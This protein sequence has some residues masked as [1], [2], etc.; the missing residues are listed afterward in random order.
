MPITS[1]TVTIQHVEYQE[2]EMKHIEQPCTCGQDG[3]LERLTIYE[4]EGDPGE[5][6]ISI[7]S[8]TREHLP[9]QIIVNKATLEQLGSDIF[10]FTNPPQE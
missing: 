7:S 1:E 8:K 5:Y 6:N 10:A 3:C 2:K 4:C 9:V